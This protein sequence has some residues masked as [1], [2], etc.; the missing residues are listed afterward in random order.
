MPTHAKLI[1]WHVLSPTALIRESKLESSL[2]R[3]SSISPGRERVQSHK[4]PCCQYSVAAL[5]CPIQKCPNWSPYCRWASPVC[6]KQCLQMQS[7]G[8]Q[9]Q[10]RPIDFSLTHI[11]IQK[12]SPLSTLFKN[13]VPFQPYL[14]FIPPS[15]P[16]IKQSD[17]LS[18]QFK[19][20]HLSVLP[21]T[22]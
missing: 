9:P 15:A 16:H 21:F 19:K 8:D 3:Q 17:L 13:T 7:P 11:N 20:T 4:V 1:W 22:P 5:T 2:S 6:L 12:H 10:S 14:S 18:L